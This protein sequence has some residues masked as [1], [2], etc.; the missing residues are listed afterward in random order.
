MSEEQEATVEEQQPLVVQKVQEQYPDAIL[1][2][3]D[4]RDELTITVCKELSLIH[5]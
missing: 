3:S 4:A 1:D 2:V 5:I